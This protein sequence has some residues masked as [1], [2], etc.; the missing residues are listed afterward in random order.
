MG[1]STPC[2]RARLLNP[3]TPARPDLKSGAVVLAW[4]PPR[5]GH[6]AIGITPFCVRFGE[7]LCSAGA[8]NGLLGRGSENVDSESRN[9]F[10]L[11]SVAEP[12]ADS[13]RLARAL[14]DPPG[15]HVRGARRGLARTADRRGA[16]LVRLVGAPDLDQ[17]LGHRPVRLFPA[18]L[19]S[20]LSSGPHPV[21]ARARAPVPRPELPNPSRRSR[22][23]SEGLGNR[24]ARLRG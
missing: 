18:L 20:G 11:G 13:H 22:E 1:I 5:G 21:C 19:Q 2:S 10:F 23:L 3:R 6:R 8:L 4:L 12:D 16:R 17:R 15:P 7:D 24:R 9:F 14:A